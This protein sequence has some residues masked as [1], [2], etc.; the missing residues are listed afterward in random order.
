MNGTST[1]IRARPSVEGLELNPTQLAALRTGYRSMQGLAPTDNRSWIYWAG[2][3]GFPQWQCWHHGRVGNMAT[4][5]YNL[6][7]PWHRAYLLYFENAV[8]DHASDA[9]IPWWDWTSATSHTIGVPASFGEPRVGNQA[10]PLYSGPAPA[11]PPDPARNTVRFPGAPT[12]LPPKASVDA[13]LDLTSFS[14]FQLQ[15]EDIHDNIHGWTG[16]RNPQAP[17]QGGDMG[18]VARA[19]FDPIFWSHHCMIDRIWYL[20]QLRQ[21]ADNIPQDYL[22]RPLAPFSLTV[23]DVLDIRRLGYEY[24]L[25]TLPPVP[26]PSA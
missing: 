24:A 2:I 8:R 1:A 5:P 6:F 22:T 10:N 16:G 7:L 4:R 19:A 12:D 11:M 13:L 21:G 15:L 14:D 9:V 23:Q 18:A 20:W 26:G 17:A 25:T 3:H